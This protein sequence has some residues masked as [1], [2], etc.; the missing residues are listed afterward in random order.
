[1][2]TTHRAALIAATAFPLFFLVAC[3]GDDSGSTEQV[4]HNEDDGHDHGVEATP[5][6][7]DRVAI[8]AS[9][10]SNLGIS[11]VTV[12]RRR[13]EQ[14]LRVP[15][16]FEYLPTARREYRTAVPG[17]VE[18]L[19]AQFQRVSAGDVLYRIDSPAWR[20]MQQQLADAEAQIQRFGARLETFEPLLA[21]HEQHEE[22]LHESVAVW[23]ERVDQLKS[24][25]EMGGGRIDELAQARAAVASNRAEL[26]SVQ[27]KKA[28]LHADRQQTQADLRA[29]EARLN[30]LLDSAAA[31]ASIDRAQLAAM[32]STDQT[33]QP[34]WA[35][36]NTIEVVATEAG[37][38]E[39]MGLTNGSWADE[40][41]P[42]MTVVQP[43][44][45]RF[46]ASGLQSDLGVLKDG[47]VARIVPPTPT[48]VGRAVPLQDTMDGTLTLGL[49]G[50]PNDRTLE[51]FVV[52]NELRSWARPG[53]SAQLEI[54][55][56]ST[57]GPE[58][59]IPLA[60]VQRDGLSP[61][62]FRRAP[63]N[64]DEAIRMEADLGKDDGRWVALLSGFRDGDEIVLDGAFQ[65]MLA[66]SG[67]IQKGGHFH[68]DGTFHEGED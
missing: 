68:S 25:R 13:I 49:A 28:E 21:A 24:V 15:G 14:T 26:A 37:I 16:R 48:A 19:A 46:R 8:S 63:D 62:I 38:V 61:V 53:I 56:D 36:V 45:L 40:K 4:A 42:V 44:R 18:L 57:A 6:S 41:T 35:T 27:E 9:V 29:A 5:E 3:N 23:N 47:L 22:S 60:A 10:R 65:L 34:G 66:T 39:A 7:S 59:A 33:T 1:M 30:Y 52:P 17:R 43:D 51:L 2:N 20:E 50:D 32:V 12:E 31:I 11:F 55:T 58:L 54:V 67:S 64:P